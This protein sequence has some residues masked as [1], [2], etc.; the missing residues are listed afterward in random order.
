MGRQ[1]RP[2]TAHAGHAARAGAPQPP[3]APPT[4]SEHSRRE[5]GPP[6]IRQQQLRTKAA[7]GWGGVGGVSGVSSAGHRPRRAA[8]SLLPEV[9]FPPVPCHLI[10]R[11]RLELTFNIPVLQSF[12]P[13]S[14]QLLGSFPAAGPTHLPRQAVDREELPCG[15][16]HRAQQRCRFR[17]RA[18]TRDV[19][20]GT[21]D[22]RCGRAGQKCVPERRP[23]AARARALPAAPPS[24]HRDL[25]PA[26]TH[27]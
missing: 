4:P 24:Q 9:R 10:N 22:G 15:G 21:Q 20:A 23:L 5:A 7:E 18:N 8:V 11:P 2:P 19:S 1:G 26:P 17:G 14:L 13:D 12:Q 16:H 3:T 25:L 27:P 6:N